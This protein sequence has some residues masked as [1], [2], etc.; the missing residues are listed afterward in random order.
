MSRAEKWAA[1][2]HR[3]AQ[4]MAA[5]GRAGRR[6]V[7]GAGPER[8]MAVQSLK[9]AGAAVLAWAAAGWWWQ[10]P[11]ALMAPWTAI[12]L[13]Q[14]TVYR[15]LR[16]GLQQV[17][18]IAAGTVLAAAAAALTPNTV[19]AMAL[20]LPVTMLIGNYARFG[21]Q[22]VYASTTALFV[23]VYGSYSGFDI[24]HRLLETFLG[25][26]IGIGVNALILPPVPLRHARDSQYRLPRDGGALLRVMAEDIESGYGPRQAQDWH[27]RALDLTRLG[28]DLRDA[29][30]RAD[31]GYRFNPAHRLRRPGPAL[32]A[33]EWDA[34]WERVAGHLSTSTRL[35]VEAVGENSRLAPPPYGTLEDVPVMLHALAD[36]CEADCSALSGS[37]EAPQEDRAEAM[38]RAWAAHGRRKSRLAERV[39]AEDQETATSVGG[40]A[41]LT[42]QL[43]HD[44]EAARP[45]PGPHAPSGDPV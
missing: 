33:A 5:I 24:L 36:V 27:R 44:L 20:A 3:V 14:S 18:L 42:Q 2:W 43:L 13:V 28:A 40:L 23:L 31:E 25:A 38:A 37:G 7:S 9:A 6:A 30:R 19:A 10:A 4:E 1:P 21:D 16:A 39:A 29:R 22:G 8:D 35:L 12:A 26:V 15:S 45:G 11:L 41:A 32:P 34:A 17:V